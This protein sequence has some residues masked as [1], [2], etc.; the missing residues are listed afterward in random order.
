MKNKIF[1]F[2][3]NLA[4]LVFVIGLLYGIKALSRYSKSLNPVS[5]ITVT[6]EGKV[7]AAPDIAKFVFSVVSEGID[8]AAIQKENTE[9]MN[10]AIEAVKKEGIEEKDIKTT[11]YSLNPKYEYDEKKRR[12]FISG[13]ELRQSVEVKIRDFAKI[14][15][16]LGELPSLGINEIGQ[17]QFDVDN[18][19]IYLD[20][21]RAEAFSKALAKARSMAKQNGA[22]IKRLITFTD[23]AGGIPPILYSEDLGIGGGIKAAAIP[24]IEPGTQEIKV[25]VA[26]T[27]EIR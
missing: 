26:V 12:S 9:K 20:Q 27:Y 1:W 16:I 4:I 22:K 3:I 13:Y 11:S 24:T 6:A 7:I 10:K 2:S 17:L 23:F 21:A 5:Q 15:A 25:Q 14:S 18:P 8:P 19:D